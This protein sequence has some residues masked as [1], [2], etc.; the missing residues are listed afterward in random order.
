MDLE[1]TKLAVA[2]LI[3]GSFLIYSLVHSQS[4]SAALTPKSTPDAVSETTASTSANSVAAAAST[5]TPTALPTT[6]NRRRSDA[7]DEGSIAPPQPTPTSASTAVASAPTPTSA[8]SG[9][10]KD[11]S[12]TGNEADAQWGYVQVQAI[13]SQ[14][15]ITD[16]KFLEYP[17]DRS[18][19]QFINSVADPE[20]VSE[21]I[22]AQSSHVDV[23]TGATDSSE[24]FMQSL[25]DALSQAIA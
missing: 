16:V 5:P 14:G 9:Q 21:A 20:L 23:I 8:S 3:I 25:A 2:V 1:M 6:T 17:S 12:Y 11:G 24:A 15:K 19:S 22:Q 13:V 18:R 4:N 10:Y 7:S